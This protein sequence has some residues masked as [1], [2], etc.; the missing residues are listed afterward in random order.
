MMTGVIL[1]G[2]QNRR[3]GG[4]HK[5]LVPIN[6]VPLL[7]IQL[8]EMARI[9]SFILIVTNV[10]ELFAPIVA[11]FKLAEVSCIPDLL[12]EKGPLSGIHAACQAAQTNRLWIV[13]CDMPFISAA[14]AEALNDLCKETCADAA[15]PVIQ[16]K[17]QPL[18]GI[19]D[20]RIVHIVK[21]LLELEVYKLMRLL[22]RIHVQTVDDAFFVDKRVSLAFTVNLNTPGEFRAVQFNVK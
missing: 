18:H 10:P 2:G 17:I 11:E 9:C 22:E 13:G 12:P 21:E 16:G 19:F 8:E 3:M 7:Q 14:A 20:K 6:G 15:V 5:A 4:A 1:A